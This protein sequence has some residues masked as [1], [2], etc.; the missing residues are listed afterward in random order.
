MYGSNPI[1]RVFF[2][3]LYSPSSLSLML[4]NMA[5]ERKS[6]MTDTE[7]VIE[8]HFLFFLVVRCFE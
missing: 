6:H 2:S 5:D 3:F 1:I 7:G 4:I 8:K